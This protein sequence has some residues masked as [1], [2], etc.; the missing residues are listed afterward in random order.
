M[1][2]DHRVKLRSPANQAGVLSL[3]ESPINGTE[4]RIRTYEK[5]VC[6]TS[7]IDRSAT[8][9]WNRRAELNCRLDLRR[10][11][12][13]PFHYACKTWESHP[14]SSRSLKFRKLALCPIE[15]WDQK[16]RAYGESNS[17]SL[18]RRQVPYALDD[19]PE[20]GASGES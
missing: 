2:G 4:G 5:L 15:L 9:A 18:F 3:Y 13:C 17:G 14:D 8:S 1:V 11:V 19:R 12:L 6:R 10:I 20:Y 7:A 16:W